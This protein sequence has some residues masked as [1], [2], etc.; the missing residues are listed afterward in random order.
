MVWGPLSPLLCLLTGA[1]WTML[2]LVSGADLVTLESAAEEEFVT[3]VV[4]GNRD[5]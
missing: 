1:P 4:L 2:L 3:T 5:V